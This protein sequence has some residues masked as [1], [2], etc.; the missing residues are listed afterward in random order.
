MNQ[1]IKVKKKQKKE[2][3]KLLTY[4]EYKEYYE[5]YKKEYLNNC[6]IR[7]KFYF[8]FSTIATVFTGF[9]FKENLSSKISCVI[10]V[11]ALIFAAM[12]LASLISISLCVKGANRHMINY[13]N[14]Y[15][16]YYKTNYSKKKRKELK[17]FLDDNPYLRYIKIIDNFLFFLTI[18]LFSLVLIILFCYFVKIIFNI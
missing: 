1:R 3:K 15:E 4:E 17:N 5:V 10:I 16:K 6:D 13:S 8:S 11:F 7:D 2:K 18:G 9:L 12:S 14:A